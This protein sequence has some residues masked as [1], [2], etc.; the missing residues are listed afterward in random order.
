M[1]LLIHTELLNK[2]IHN[3]STNTHVH[4]VLCKNHVSLKKGQGLLERIFAS[5]QKYCMPN[6]KKLLGL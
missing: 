6:K 5:K 3:D 1:S 4:N 2:G